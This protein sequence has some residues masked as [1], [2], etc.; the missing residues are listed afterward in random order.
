MGKAKDVWQR[1]GVVP[2]SATG[3]VVVGLII[4]VVASLLQ[5]WGNPPNMGICTACFERDIA[6]AIGL[7]RFAPAQY[8]RPE[9]PGFVL[10][11]MLAALLFG[12]FRPRGGSMPMLRFTLGA[13]A[14]IASLVFLG[15]TWRAFL[16][17]AGGDGTALAGLAGLAVGIAAGSWFLKRGFTLGSARSVVP[18]AGLVMPAFMALLLALL[19]AGVWFGAGQPFY[20][21]S[22]GPGAMHA[23][24]AASLGVGLL[25]GILGQ[26][27]RFC[28]VGAVREIL[29]VRNARLL[30]GVAAMVIGAMAVNI[31]LGQF[32]V[33]MAAAPIAHSDHL[34]NFLS[35]ILAGLAFCLSGGCPGR[36]LFLCG[37]GNTDSSIFVTGMIVGAAVA[38][39]WALTGAPDRIVQGVLQ[40]GGPGLYAKI[41]IA[42]GFAFCIAVGFTARKRELPVKAE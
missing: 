12:E 25:V 33:S 1:I 14:M 5:W 24:I 21:S 16:R 28:T 13:F 20:S 9:I 8:L 6:G 31:A 35:M 23:S 4:G 7:H 11:A 26:R 30:G 40:V 41:A 37:E 19:I 17:L 3:L 10:G 18:A 29:L 38:H 2:A 42:V 34:W 36:H 22:K 32:K 27:S 15:C 39:N